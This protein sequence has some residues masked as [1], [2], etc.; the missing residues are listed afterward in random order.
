MGSRAGRERVSLGQERRRGWGVAT[1]WLAQALAGRA[2]GGGGRRR[3]G[4]GEG[5]K[6]GKT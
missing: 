3:V 2:P 6:R 4:L 5:Q 1:E